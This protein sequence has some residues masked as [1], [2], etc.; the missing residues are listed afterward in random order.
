M[1]PRQKRGFSEG[2]ERESRKGWLAAVS[3][4]RDTKRR[5]RHDGHAKF[6]KRGIS[7]S[8]FATVAP[9]Q[10]GKTT[11]QLNESMLNNDIIVPDDATNISFIEIPILHVECTSPSDQ[12]TLIDY[13]EKELPAVGWLLMKKRGYIYEKEALRIL[14][15]ERIGSLRPLRATRS[16]SK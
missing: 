6:F 13:Y 5:Q 16:R 14:K 11:I 8:T 15:K 12:K 10:G 1:S 7:L 9:A 3:K 2:I 4:D